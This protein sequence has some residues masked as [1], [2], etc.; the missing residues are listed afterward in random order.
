MVLKLTDIYEI[1]TSAIVYQLVSVGQ[2]AG[3]GLGMGTGGAPVYPNPISDLI[4]TRKDASVQWPQTILAADT[5]RC[6]VVGN[7]ARGTART[8]LT[9]WPLY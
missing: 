5:L 4:L 2:Y 6:A 9:Q 8:D 1:D 7:P 3:L